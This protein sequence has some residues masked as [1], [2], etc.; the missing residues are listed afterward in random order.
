MWPYI[1]SNERLLCAFVYIVTL[2]APMYM[3]FEAYLLFN[4]PLCLRRFDLE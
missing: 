1:E 3:F 4:S 2:S